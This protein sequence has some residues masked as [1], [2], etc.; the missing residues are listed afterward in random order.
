[1]IALLLLACAGDPSGQFAAGHAAWADGRPEVALQAWSEVAAAGEPS[2][3][4]DYDLGTASLQ[5]GA[6]DR[7][8]AFLRAAQLA[9]PRSAD[10]A[11][12][13]ALARAGVRGTPPPA[14]PPV[15][16][17]DLLTP[18]ELGMLGVLWLALFSVAAVAWRRR[19]VPAAT[20]VLPLILGVLCLITARRGAVAAVQTP[21]V[22]VVGADAVARDA[23][24]LE[25][26]ERFTLSPGSELVQE[27][28]AGAFARVV[29]G[30]GRRG[31]VPAVAISAG[32]R[33]LVEHS[34][35]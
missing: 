19:G 32:A 28:R 1:V 18:A 13:L 6:P 15:A 29:D 30:E 2:W 12:N 3:V 34:G 21:V 8:V 35:E 10:V 22:V 23:P 16:F 14:R 33:D 17:L 7:A 4:L 27:A 9:N 25:A 5:A 11:H 31:W 20:W 26:V 24:S